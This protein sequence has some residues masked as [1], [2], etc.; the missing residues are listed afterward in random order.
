MIV[1]DLINSEGIT[2]ISLWLIDLSF[3][4]PSVISLADIRREYSVVLA[5]LKISPLMDS[6]YDSIGDN[7]IIKYPYLM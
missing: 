3:L 1:I 4:E 5:I 6:N 2:G 7:N